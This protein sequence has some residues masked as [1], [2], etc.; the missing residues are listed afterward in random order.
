MHTIARLLSI[1]LAATPL[2]I[3]FYLVYKLLLA[4]DS[5]HRLNR[6]LLVI[7]PPVT[8]GVLPLTKYILRLTHSTNSTHSGVI[9]IV[10][11]GSFMKPADWIL[12]GYAAGIAVTL[13]LTVITYM[14]IAGI[15]GK[16]SKIAQ[17]RFT[18][19]VTDKSD[20]VPFS[21]MRYIVIP[22]QDYE[23]NAG[24][25]ILHEK[26]HLVKH[27]WLDM[28]VSQLVIIVNWFNPAAWL[29]R[30]EL[31]SV[32]EFQADSAVITSGADARNYQMLLI[33]KAMGRRFPSLA[34]SLNH[35]S[36]KRRIDMMISP[37]RH[38]DMSLRMAALLLSATAAVT[39]LLTPSVDAYLRA[40]GRMGLPT[41]AVNRT[42]TLDGVEIYLNGD[43]ISNE[44]MQS[45]S[46]DK[47]RSVEVNK[48][49][50]DNT[51]IS[52]DYED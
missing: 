18:L 45:L 17:G 1:S 2:L 41:M 22:R 5:R 52:I 46:P 10:S 14:R 23:Q 8:F 43:K 34:N 28:I 25:I 49:Q 19:V 13:L 29:L 15:I 26:C 44:E 38:R 51:I 33:A 48:S 7:V 24:M 50:K 27:H 35:S 11:V 30:E 16:G 40:V 31:K 3:G 20:I 36:L 47:I 42:P 12:W 39:L 32:H 21:W 37:R 6:V 9:E 4:G